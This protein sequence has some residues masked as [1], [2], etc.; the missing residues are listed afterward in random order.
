MSLV[1]HFARGRLALAG[2]TIATAI[3]SFLSAGILNQ[4]GRGQIFIGNTGTI[5]A[6]LFPII[7]AFIFTAQL[8]VTDPRKDKIYFIIA[9]TLGLAIGLVLPSVAVAIRTLEYVW[10]LMLFAMVKDLAYGSLR[11][12]RLSKIFVISC[13]IA[14]T[15]LYQ[16]YSSNWLAFTII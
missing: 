4:L 3:V 10:C 1:P 16:M 15:T 12:N 8:F 13:F 11:N 9:A 5:F 6:P 14:M 2:M 7:T